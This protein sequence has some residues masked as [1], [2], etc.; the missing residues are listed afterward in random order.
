MCEYL[1]LK[2]NNLGLMLHICEPLNRLCTLCIYGNKSNYNQIKESEN[3]Y[4]QQ[5]SIY[6]KA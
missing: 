4:A 2:E 1:R 5:K 3:S 6:C